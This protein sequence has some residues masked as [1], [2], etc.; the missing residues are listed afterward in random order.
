MKRLVLVLCAGLCCSV[1]AADTVRIVRA[2]V[3]VYLETVPGSMTPEE[4][5][6]KLPPIQELD[7]VSRFVLA[8][9]I[10]GWRYSYTPSDKTRNVAE[11]FSLEPLQVI[12]RGDP[13]FSLSKLTPDYPRLSCWAEF[14]LDDSLARWTDSWNSVLYKNVRGRG[15]GERTD[16]IA[17]IKTAYTQAV[18]LA[19]REAARK[20]EKNKPKEIRGE[21]L[22]RSEPRLF[23]EEGWFVADLRLLNHIDEIVLYQ[24]F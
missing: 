7:E 12:P 22:L 1:A 10:Y 3:W 15:R 20:L 4:L 9:M 21:V 16:E 23:V 13:R 17:G 2:P 19:V 24:T 14:T 8:G 18:L 11:F 6:A 5:A